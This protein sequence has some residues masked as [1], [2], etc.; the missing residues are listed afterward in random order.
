MISR[1]GCKNYICVYNKVVVAVQL[2]TWQCVD[3]LR[4]SVSS[5]RLFG[6]P[7]FTVLS[8]GVEEESPSEGA[9]PLDDTIVA[10]VLQLSSSNSSSSAVISS[11]VLNS[12]TSVT[13]KQSSSRGAF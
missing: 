7:L 8:G 11:M 9:A 6:E 1:F 12:V 13:V 4:R 2:V 3:T 5:R 10:V